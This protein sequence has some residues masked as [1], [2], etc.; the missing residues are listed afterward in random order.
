MAQFYGLAKL[1]TTRTE[2]KELKLTS[3]KVKTAWNG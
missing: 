2:V 1:G 3:L